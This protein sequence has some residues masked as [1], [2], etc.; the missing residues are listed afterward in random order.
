MSDEEVDKRFDE[1]LAEVLNDVDGYNKLYMPQ[2]I[3]KLFILCR[4]VAVTEHLT[5]LL[6]RAVVQ[7]FARSPI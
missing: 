1:I 5:A 6:F 2:I 4:E 3:V 7:F